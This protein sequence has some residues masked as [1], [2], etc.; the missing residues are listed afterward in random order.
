MGSMICIPKQKKRKLKY[1]E[2][3]TNKK[4]KRFDKTLPICLICWDTIYQPMSIC[5][6]ICDIRIHAVCDKKY[7][8]FNINANICPHC[9]QEGTLT[10]CINRI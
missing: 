1:I 6:Q 9:R 5:C 10:I 7:R 3:T 8:E 4:I 2:Y